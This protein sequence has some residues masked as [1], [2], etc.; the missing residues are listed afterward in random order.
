MIMQIADQGALDVLANLVVY[1]ERESV[2]T[3]SAKT[4]TTIA[5]KVPS[6]R[7]HIL[8]ISIIPLISIILTSIPECIR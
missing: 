3:V 2:Q 1:G 5:N 8:N 4:L 7:A 6:L